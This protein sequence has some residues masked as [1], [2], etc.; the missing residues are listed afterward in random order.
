MENNYSKL[1]MLIQ[2]AH[3]DADFDIKEMAF[4]YNV[5][6]R[7]NIN[8]DIIGDLIDHP[9]PLADLNRLTREGK[10]ECMI[11][12]IQLML[13]DGKVL[14]KEIEF[15]VTIGEH[16]GFETDSLKE[17]I[18]EVKL[19]MHITTAELHKKVHQLVLVD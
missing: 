9:V 15:L 3:A 1:S 19:L 16:L 2:L 18:A 10:A 4:I 6:L 17:L 11:D 13:V 8:L 14:P 7:H 12:A 5:G